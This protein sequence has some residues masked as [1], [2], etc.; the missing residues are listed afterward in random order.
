MEDKD[1]QTEGKTIFPSSLNTGRGL[2]LICVELPILYFK[3]SQIEVYKLGYISNPSLEIFCIFANSPD[4]D[5]MLPY[6]AL[7]LG[8]YCLPKYLFT[9]FQNE[10]GHNSY[11][12]MVLDR[13]RDI[14]V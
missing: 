9:G 10:K 11:P 2:S 13:N 14:I 3:G 1:E 4:P 12:K 8:L 7:Y 6:A 5:E